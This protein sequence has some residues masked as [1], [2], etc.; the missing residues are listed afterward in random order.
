VHAARVVCL[1]LVPTRLH[2]T[3]VQLGTLLASVLLTKSCRP[4]LFLDTSR[5]STHGSLP[6]GAVVEGVHAAGINTL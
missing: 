1:S 4:L 5:R 6:A 2:L 3:L